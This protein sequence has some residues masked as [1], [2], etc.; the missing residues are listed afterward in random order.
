LELVKAVSNMAPW[1]PSLEQA[2]STG[3]LYSAGIPLSPEEL[4]NSFGQIFFGPVVLVTDAYC[5]S[6]CDMFAAGFQDHEIGPVL[7][8]DET[9]G[10]GG[11]N[12]VTHDSLVSD[13]TGGPLQTLPGNAKMRV[14][15]RRTLRVGARAGEPI[16]DLG[17]MRDEEHS[18][19]RNDLL[20]GNVDLLDTAGALLAQKK[21][22]RFEH[23]PTS[24][25]QMLSISLTTTNVH[26]VDIYVNDR[27]AN[28]GTGISDGTTNVSNSRPPSGA[29]LRI[30]GFDGG[31]LV[32]ARKI[33]LP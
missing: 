5:Y 6:A 21:P 27:P 10:A 12:V 11:A 1:L 16:E 19:T 7:G 33:R 4:V 26:S 3:A 31:E 8:V 30:E 14:S 20:N 32:A 2:V 18:M 22:R 9:T 29:R 24:Q 28:S 15:L 13:W 23:N 25:K 17:I